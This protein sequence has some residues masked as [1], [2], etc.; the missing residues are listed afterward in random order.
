MVGGKITN[1]ILEDDRARLRVEDNHQDTCMIE[2]RSV[3]TKI[4]V[5]DRIWWR[6]RKAYWSPANEVLDKPLERIGY[7]YS[8]KD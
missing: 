1:V 2:V 7:S 8:P 3:G 6:G 5:G 4:K